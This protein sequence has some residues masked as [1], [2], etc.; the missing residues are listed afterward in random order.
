MEEHISNW[1]FHY[2]TALVGPSWEN[3]EQYWKWIRGSLW[4]P[5]VP[6]M[7]SVVA[8]KLSQLTASAPSQ[9]QDGNIPTS[10]AKWQSCE[11]GPALH[12]CSIN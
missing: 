6:G 8:I 7:E 3:Q 11:M 12:V 10:L 9:I 5:M 1:L 2:V 4:A